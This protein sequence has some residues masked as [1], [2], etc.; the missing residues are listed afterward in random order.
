MASSEYTDIDR[1]FE[2]IEE[3]LGKELGK[4]IN[5]SLTIITPVYVHCIRLTIAN[6]YDEEGRRYNFV[7]CKQHSIRYIFRYDRISFSYICA[8][9]PI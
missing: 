4:M 3:V 8:S 6:A 1:Q 2:D 5:E 9:L 7:N